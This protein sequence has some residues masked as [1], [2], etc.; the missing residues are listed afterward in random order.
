MR[1]RLGLES[2]HYVHLQSWTRRLLKLQFRSY[3]FSLAARIRPVRIAV[4]CND[5]HGKAHLGIEVYDR[6]S[7][8]VKNLLVLQLQ[9]VLRP[10]AI[11]F[12]DPAIV[13][14]YFLQC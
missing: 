5:D 11:F 4:R 9:R 6:S 12:Y 13:F 2:A 14:L 8:R 1:R 7:N 3:P 10:H